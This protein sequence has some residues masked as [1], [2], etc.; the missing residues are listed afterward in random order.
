[1]LNTV[2][3]VLY[4]FTPQ[5]R[6][7]LEKHIVT[8]LFEKYPIFYGTQRF[9]IVFTRAHHWSLTWAHWIQFTHLQHI[10]LRSILILSSKLHL[11]LPGGLFH[12]SFIRFCMHFYLPYTYFMSHPSEPWFSHSKKNWYSSSSCNFLHPDGCIYLYMFYVMECM[13]PFHVDDSFSQCFYDVMDI[14][15]PGDLIQYLLIKFLLL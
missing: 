4:Q 15:L 5:S 11:G 3:C 14:L 7:L 8:Q 2:L 9:I 13:F 6:A 12:S 1:M 10:A